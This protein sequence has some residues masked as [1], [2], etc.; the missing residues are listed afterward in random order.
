MNRL[1]VKWSTT[2]NNNI[3]SFTNDRVKIIYIWKTTKVRSLFLLKDKVI[4]YQSSV[5]YK[6]KCTTCNTVYIGETKINTVIRWKEHN[7]NSE[8]SEPSK[9]LVSNP[10]HAFNWSILS[11]APRDTNKRK[12][13][14]AFSIRSQGRIQEFLV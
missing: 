13:L 1:S 6:G 7:S 2:W 9:H 3:E 11:K 12:I 8:K 10:N 14:E 5:I 4:N